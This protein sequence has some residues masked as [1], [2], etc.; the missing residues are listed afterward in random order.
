VTARDVI[1]QALALS[2]A[3]TDGWEV[4]H[5]WAYETDGTRLINVFKAE[6]WAELERRQ[7]D[8][9]RAQR[10][11]EFA[12]AARTLLPALA[13]ALGD[14]LDLHQQTTAYGVP[15]CDM[16]AQVK[17]ADEWDDPSDDYSPVAS[18]LPFPCPT[19]TA[20]TAALSEVTP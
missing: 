18:W 7:E 8:E 13:K 5:G 11:I 9:A 12:A 15:V 2:E 20:I 10:N 6:R 4:G 16:C 14:V 17:D 3:A 19:V 1:A